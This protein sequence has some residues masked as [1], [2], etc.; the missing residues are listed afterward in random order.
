MLIKKLNKF[1]SIF[2]EVLDYHYQ[3]NFKN[4]NSDDDLA[5]AIFDIN[6]A[7]EA[8]DNDES[9]DMY[10]WLIKLKTQIMNFREQPKHNY[11]I[12]ITIILVALALIGGYTIGRQHTIKSA[13][14]Y[15][16]TDD[17]YDIIFGEEIHN[18]TFEEV[19]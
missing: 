18:Y 11:S 4:L 17:G 10:R 12:V 6:E 19:K 14:L 5:Q 8:Y 9:D 1:Y 7:L 2:W 16:I 3:P 15:T 13:E